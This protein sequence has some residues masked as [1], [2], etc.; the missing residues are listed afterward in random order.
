MADIRKMNQGAPSSAD[1][2]VANETIADRA[3]AAADTAK[4][5]LGQAGE[6]AVETYTAG[7]AAV[8]SRVDVIPAMVMSALA[9]VLVGYCLGSDRR[10]W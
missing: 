5:T 1:A 10:N 4:E 2:L 3:R 6:R 8:A 9:G 7:N